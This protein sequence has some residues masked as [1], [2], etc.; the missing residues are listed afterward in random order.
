MAIGGEFFNPDPES[1]LTHLVFKLDDLKAH[2]S[3]ARSALCTLSGKE[4][5]A[6]AQELGRLDSLSCMYICI[7]G[8]L[9]G[10][11]LTFHFS[12]EDRT[13]RP[14]VPQRSC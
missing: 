5:K 7:T 13:R 4:L 1:P 10:H 14:A 9:V 12:P 6:K 2:C 8:P 3:D 11:R